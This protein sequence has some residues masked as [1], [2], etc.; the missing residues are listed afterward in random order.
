[1]LLPRFASCASSSSSSSSSSSRTTTAKTKRCSALR[2][3][4]QRVM[5]KAPKKI[6]R[7]GK[8][9]KNSPFH[10]DGQRE[11]GR[12]QRA[13]RVRVRGVGVWRGARFRERINKSRQYR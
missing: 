7:V 5:K 6:K 11:A 1:M 12:E 8:K 4:P 9:E 13:L 10:V 3:I 2:D